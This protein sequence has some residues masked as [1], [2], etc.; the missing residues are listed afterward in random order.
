MHKVNANFGC[1]LNVC[2]ANRYEDE[3]D[4]LGWHA[5][6]AFSIDQTQPIASISFGAERE[7]WWKPIGYKSPSVFPKEWRCK[8]EDGSA[9]IMPVGMQSTHMHKIPKHDSKCGY[10]ISLTFMA[11]K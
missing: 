9:F 7:I 1:R 2:F 10:R 4:A 11:L 8:L 3:K 5:D 6:D